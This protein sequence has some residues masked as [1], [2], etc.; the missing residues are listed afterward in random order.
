MTITEEEKKF[1]RSQP[2]MKERVEFLFETLGYSMQDIQDMIDQEEQ[3]L[4][5]TEKEIQEI[6]EQR[7]FS[8]L[9]QHLIRM[10]L[11]W[12]NEAEKALLEINC[13]E[14]KRIINSITNSYRIYLSNI[15][16]GHLI[17]RSNV[18]Q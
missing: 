3:P 18:L 10:A 15:G 6:L 7:N 5:Y 4:K 1:I 16:L 9:K 12:E 14:S 13:E 17:K 8:K 11:E 2:N